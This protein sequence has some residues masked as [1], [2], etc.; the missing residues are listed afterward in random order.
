LALIASCKK[1]NKNG[2]TTPTY[3]VPTTYNFSN[4]NDSNSVKLL[5]MADQIG[6][7]INTANTIPGTAVSAQVLKDMFNNANGYFVDSSLKLNGSG[8]RLA[9]YCSAAAKTDLLNYFDSIGL[10]SQST[11]AASNGVAG[12]SASSVSAS[13][14]YLLSPNGVFYSQ[15][16][17]KTIHGGILQ[18]SIN[19]Y[20]T[21]SLNSGTNQEHYWDLAFGLFGVPVTFPTTTTGLKYLA[22]YSNQVEAGLGS[23]E[24]LMN[25][26]LKGRAAVSAKDMTTAAQQATVIIKTL[27]SLDA[28]AIVQEM[29]ETDANIEA[30]DAVAA[31]G[32]M[33]ESLG[34]IRNL[35]YNTSSTRAISDAQFSQLLALVDATNPNTPNLYLFVN[36]NVS[37]KTQIEAK[38]DAIRQFIGK[39]Y[40]F[41]ATQLAAQ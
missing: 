2:P 10:Y 12:V 11:V 28:A 15:I 29:K 6:A 21:D 3:T 18:Y 31:Y 36:A 35:K 32:T 25:A 22:S 14:K 17:K 26:F 24:K 40:G 37:T 33:S 20:L 5:L 1:D 23:N 16:Y 38:T 7:K 39:T 9:D 34:F 8:L 30:G 13:K 4:F 19:H 41:S 27:D